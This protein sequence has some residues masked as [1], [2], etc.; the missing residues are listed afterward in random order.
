MYRVPTPPQPL[1]F[2]QYF[3]RS[4]IIRV[5]SELENPTSV[6]YLGAELSIV[7]YRATGYCTSVGLSHGLSTVRAR[8][9]R[10]MTAGNGQR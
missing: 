3:T 5:S 2:I 7:L 9:G 1:R 10:A 8:V 4:S 6:F